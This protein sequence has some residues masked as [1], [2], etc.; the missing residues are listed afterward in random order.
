MQG[1]QPNAVTFNK[2]YINYQN[3]FNQHFRLGGEGVVIFL[4]TILTLIYVQR[5]DCMM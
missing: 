3:I 4:Q 5:I 1:I 2:N